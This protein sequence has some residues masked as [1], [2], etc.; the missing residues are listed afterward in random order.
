MISR[1]RRLVGALALIGAF[2]A[3]APASAQTTVIK[4]S[5]WLPVGQ[6]MRME[7]IE[8]WIAE[9]E[10]VTAGR[11]KIDTLPKV[12]GTL[13]AQFDV[14]RDGQADL[15]VFIP[16]YTPNRFDILEALQMPFVSDNPEVLAPLA[17]RFFRKHLA[18]YGEFK[19]VHP[20]SVYVVSPGQLFNNK[21]PLR[22]IA[23]FKG[24]KF[25]SPQPSATQALTLLG[26]VPVNKPVSE[27]YELMSSG[28]LDGTLMPP[29]SIPAFKL[30]DLVPYATIVPGAIYN[31]VLVLGINEDKWKS[32]R[33][34]DREA[35][36][37]ISGD[38]FA[39]KIGAAYAKG[40]RAA[41]D[42]LRKA[43]KSVETASPALVDE[44]KKVLAPVEKDW[45]EKAKKKGVADPQ[46][47]LDELR[48]EVA[49]ASRGK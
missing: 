25:R 8:P 37:R 41:F 30:N 19:G 26:A 35:I 14:A 10:K 21:R 27:T 3:A 34:E 6:A 17:D 40:D 1:T 28:V 42:G 22:S 33:A 18:S 2:A 15:V 7:V 32:L 43:G 24:L 4:Y 5:N 45:I 12:V 44:M 48:A 49:A 16:G 39:A 29:E 31:T 38:A 13:P 23:D 11:V 47:L 9:V 20:L 46:K 36:T